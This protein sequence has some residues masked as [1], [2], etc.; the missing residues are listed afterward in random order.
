VVLVVGAANSSNSVRLWEIAQTAGT[1]A[2]RIDDADGL[3]PAWLE[4]ASSVGITAGASAPDDLVQGL[5]ARIGSLFDTT[6]TILDGVEEDVHFRLPP[7]VAHGVTGQT[8][9]GAPE[10]V[11]PESVGA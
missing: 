1:P 3:D 2:Y 11:G 10:S 8:Q 6:V 9:T 7:E 5:V 4:G